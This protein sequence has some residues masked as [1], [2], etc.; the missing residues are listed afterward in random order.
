MHKKVPRAW[1]N[2]MVF[3]KNTDIRQVTASVNGDTAT[4][5]NGLSSRVTNPKFNI[6]QP[7]ILLFA[8]G[9][10]IVCSRCE[11][12]VVKRLNA[13]RKLNSDK[14][15]GVRHFVTTNLDE[16][17]EW[18]HKEMDS[19]RIV[20]S[21]FDKKTGEYIYKSILIDKESLPTKE[22]WDNMETKEKSH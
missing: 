8:I 19:G 13:L 1:A 12:G 22:E 9:L 16:A 11:S 5:V 7:I 10:M 4:R 3:E 14:V 15:E 17:R 2:T 21:H 20:Y 6:R 18:G